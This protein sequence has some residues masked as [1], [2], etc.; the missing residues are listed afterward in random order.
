MPMR[1]KSLTGRAL[2]RYSIHEGLTSYTHISDQY[3]TFGTQI[4]VTTE[5]DATFTLDEILGNTTELPIVEHTT[6]S[7][8]Q[9]LATF[10]LFDLTGYRLSPRL[11]KLAEAPLWRSHPPSHY[12]RWP[13]AGPLLGH[14][15]QVDVIAEHWDDLVR[16]GG[17][18]KLGHVSAALLI[19]ARF[20]ADASSKTPSNV[21][22]T[23]FIAGALALPLRW[24]SD[25]PPLQRP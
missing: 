5:R 19:Q 8:G 22:P 6:D 12:Q 10:A 4:V 23:T 9:T 14:H 7:H 20:S 1:G 17:S 11:A 16:I 21:L 13:L 3:S 18:L 25:G 24:W 15:A 2:A